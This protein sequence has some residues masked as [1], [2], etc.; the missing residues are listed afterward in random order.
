[1]ARFLRFLSRP[2]A[3]FGLGWILFVGV[4][5]GAMFWGGLNWAID[6]TNSEA[7]CISCHEMEQF[8]FREYKNTVHYT[9]RTGVRATCPDCHVPK[10]WFHKMARKIYS[11]NELFHH[12]AG[13]IS[14]PEKYEAKRL[15]LARTVW[16]TMKANDSREC[17]NCHSYE[18]MD[19]TA[20]G[21]ISRSM[22]EEGANEA[23]TC[24]DCHKGVAHELP[25]EDYDG[26]PAVHRQ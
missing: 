6:A 2:S 3:Q 25:A 12:I 19:I 17:R 18:F 4:V 5:I 10:N 1:M 11:S 16:T 21:S 22:H 9:N 26:G 15:E 13:T 8:V 7:F 24:I 14:T 20:Q 23:K